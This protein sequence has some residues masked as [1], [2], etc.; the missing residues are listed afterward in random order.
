MQK[1]I[2]VCAK[3]LKRSKELRGNVEHP[4]S[5]ILNSPNVKARV[6]LLLFLSA[7]EVLALE[8][9]YV[10]PLSFGQPI[11]LSLLNEA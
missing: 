3:Q 7:N 8:R 9:A 4:I 1:E 6:I 10:T 5:D 2:A 11:F